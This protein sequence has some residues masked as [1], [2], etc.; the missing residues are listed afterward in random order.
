M[1]NINRHS[2]S[3]SGYSLYSLPW[4][5][6]GGVGLLFTQSEI[7]GLGYTHT[8]GCCFYKLKCLEQALGEGRGG[9]QQHCQ[10]VACDFREG[11]NPLSLFPQLQSGND[12]SLR[13]LPAVKS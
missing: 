6:G 13:L 7:T 8:S 5:F 11:D 4:I 10:Q 12:D 1:G 2:G 9:R 3:S